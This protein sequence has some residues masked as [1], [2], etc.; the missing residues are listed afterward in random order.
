M[1]PRQPHRQG[2]ARGAREL[3]ARRADPGQRRAALRHRDGGDCSC[4]SAAAPSCS[5]ARTTSAASSRAWSTSRATATTPASGCGWPTSSRRRSAGESVEFTARVSES[6]LARLQFVVRVP[7]PAGAHARRVDED[8]LERSS[9]RRPAPG[10]RTSA[11]RCAAE[12]GEEA[13]DRLMERYGRAFP[14]AYKED[15]TSARAWPTSPTSTR[16]ATHGHRRSQLYRRPTRPPT[17]AASSS[18]AASPLSPDRHPADVHPHG[19]R[20]RRRAALRGVPRRRRPTCSSTTSACACR[21]AAIW[22][23]CPHDRLRDAVPGR[24][25]RGVGRPAPRATG[26]TRS[27]SAPG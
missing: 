21:N 10:T 9:S 24:G 6:A 26:S 14:E 5:C 19:R 18:T 16:S 20:G 8:A 7:E 17:C 25:R 27:S 11:T 22:E 23:E 15:F 2:P 4:R 3:P 1:A 13:G 12:H